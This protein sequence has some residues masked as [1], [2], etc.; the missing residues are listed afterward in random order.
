MKNKSP[1]LAILIGEKIRK[2]RH[3]C[4]MSQETLA[5]KTGLHRTYIGSCER[6]Q[7]NITILTLSIIC[8]ALDIDL[9][10]FFLDDL[11]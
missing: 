2:Y 8:Q 4:E 3:I 6:G 10:T 9:A 11:K 7:R 5:E 1:D